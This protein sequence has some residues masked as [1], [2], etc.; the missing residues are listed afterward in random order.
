MKFNK[1]LLYNISM[2]TAMIFA[3]IIGVVVLCITASFLLWSLTPF[4]VVIE[5]LK[6]MPF[7]GWR[8]VLLLF[9]LCFW[10]I[11]SAD[12]AIDR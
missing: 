12:T 6:D 11:V 4:V 5:A 2:S 1:G 10:C 3:P 9:G 8:L 7:S